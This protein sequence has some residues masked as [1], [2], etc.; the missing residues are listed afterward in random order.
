MGSS[1]PKPVNTLLNCGV[2][3]V[4]IRAEMK[5]RVVPS[6]SCMSPDVELAFCS[7]SSDVGALYGLFIGLTFG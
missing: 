5:A 6:S 2:T 1:A 4:G 7:C 3:I